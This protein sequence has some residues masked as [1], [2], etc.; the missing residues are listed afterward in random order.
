MANGFVRVAPDSTGK[1]L[2]TFENT[3]GGNLVEAEAVALV[4]TAGVPIATLPVSGPITDAQLRASAV[5]V[6]IPVP[7]PVSDNGGTLTVDAPVGTPV[8]SRLSDGAAA[9]IGQKAMASSLPVVV[10]SDQSAVPIS[11]ASLPSHP[12]TNAGTFATQANEVPDATATYA[13]SN[14]TS[15][16]Y[17]TNRVIKASAGVLFCLTGYNSKT[18]AQFIQLHNA[19]ALPADTAVP[20]I[21]FTVPASSNFSLDFGGKFGRFFSTGIV[22]C[23]SSTGPTKTIGSADC[24]FD[25]QFK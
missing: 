10:A 2:Q 21:T 11:A 20:A 24:W 15:A 3:V 23:N 17:E 6:T 22:V 1:L 7:A 25:A 16:A 12:V 14:A 18:S 19:T 5:P 8:F 4:D 13:P 9:L